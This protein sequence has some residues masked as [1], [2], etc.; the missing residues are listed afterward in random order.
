MKFSVLEKLA[1]DWAKSLKSNAEAMGAW[2]DGGAANFLA[3]F[4]EFKQ[5]QVVKLDLRP[6]EYKMLDDVEV[7]E[8]DE[9]RTMIEAKKHEL[10][11]HIKL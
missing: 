10:I 5:K 2:G 3:K 6:S 4:N 7:G 9:F 8:P 11:N 1:Q